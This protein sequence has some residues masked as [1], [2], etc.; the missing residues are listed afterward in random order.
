MGIPIQSRLTSLD[1]SVLYGE[2]YYKQRFGPIPYARNEHWLNFFG[3]IAQNLIDT[4]RPKSVY[5]AGCAWGFL[6]EAFRDRGVEA[7]GCDISAFAIDQVRDDIRPYCSVASLSQPIPAGPYDLVTCIEVLEHMEEWEALQAV[8]EIVKVTGTVLFSST[9]NDF[10]EPTHINVQPLMYWLEVF[11][12]TGFYPDPLFDAGFI[13]PHAFLLRRRAE[14]LPDDF[15]LLY[16]EVLRGRIDRTAFL[17][18]QARVEQLEIEKGRLTFELQRISGNASEF[19]QEDLRAMEASISKETDAWRD[20]QAELQNLRSRLRFSQDQLADARSQVAD[21]NQ[22]IAD[23]QV[24]LVSATIQADEVRNQLEASQKQLSDLHEL[25]TQTA[26]E[27]RQARQSADLLPE[28]KQQLTSVSEELVRWKMEADARASA[29]QQAERL[30]VELEDRLENADR[31]EHLLEEWRTHCNELS[32][33]LET[34]SRRNEL[35]DTQLESISRN[36]G[37]RLILQGRAWLSKNRWR[38]A[39]VR[40]RLEPAIRWCLRRAVNA[41]PT[42]LPTPFRPAPAEIAAVANASLPVEIRSTTSP[43]FRA[44]PADYQ[45]WI[46]EHEPTA[47]QLDIQRKLAGCL[48]YQPKISVLTPVFKVPLD[49]L[50][51]TVDSVIAQTYDNWE[52]CITVPSADNPDASRYLQFEASRDPRIRVKIIEKNEGIS[53]NS[54]LALSLATGEF[55]A[56]LDHDDTLAPF[57]LFEV[58]QLLNQDHAVDFIYSDKDLITEDGKDRFQPLFKPKWS[59]ELM[60]NANYLTH[61]CVMRTQNVR[62]VGG[63]RKETDGAQDWDLFLRLMRRFGKVR[64]IPKVLYHWR[65]ISTSVAQGGLQAKPYADQAQ[66]RAVQDHCEALGLHVEVVRHETGDLRILWPAGEG[67]VSIVYVSGRSDERT[68]QRAKDLSSS[69]TYANYEILLPYGES[70]SF[71]RLRCIGVSQQANLRERIDAAVREASGQTLVFI[72]ECVTPTGSEWLGELVG[73]LRL[74]GVGLVGARLLD[75]RT[76]MLRHCGIVFTEDGC[77]ENIYAGQPEH[78]YE[79]FGGASWYRNWS[80]ISGSCFAIDRDLWIKLGGIEGYPLVPRPD[81]HLS[82]KIRLQVGLR[83]VYNPYARFLQNG[84]AELESPLLSFPAKEGALRASFPDGDPYFNVNLDCQNGRVTYQDKQAGRGKSGGTDYAAD[85]RAL[86]EIFDFSP[87]QFKRSRD[88]QAKRLTRRME[89]VT[90]FLP[91]FSNAFYGGVHT[92]LRFAAAFHQEY[93][94]RS[95]FCI[96]GSSPVTLARSRI[97]A[98][99]PNLADADVIVLNDHHRVNELPESDAA[100]CSLWTT[101]Y[102]SLEFNKTRRK[103]YFIQDDESLFYPAGSISALVEATYGFGFHGICNTVSLLKR[104]QARGGH[105]EFFNPCI[106]P[107]I[108]HDRKRKP[109]QDSAPYTIFCY[110][111][112]DHPRNS[113]ELLAACLRDIKQRLGDEVSL[114]T[115]GAEWDLKEHALEGVVENLGLL[116]YQTTGALYRTCDLGLVMM[117]TRHPSYLPME[118]MACGSVVISNRNPDTAWFLKDGENCLLADPSPTSLTERIMQGIED[119][120]MRRRIAARAKELIAESYSNWREPIEKIHRFMVSQC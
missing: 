50:R 18:R 104:Y 67:R 85:S 4:I 45:G 2:D 54:N 76:H 22:R 81:I 58:T 42:P 100:V 65:Q 77:S 116:N 102:A 40:N 47:A 107:N 74:D 25:R 59:P 8:E 87:S 79:Q 88:I 106:D 89:S 111:R 6:V 19:T 51:A 12:K 7:R 44:G 69:T 31:S 57:A 48:S 83:I 23:V 39:W 71:G 80:A 16:S 43:Q 82:L 63:W 78:V 108:F 15:L 90:W 13:A 41:E 110:A 99:F 49:V 68:L 101:A 113:F 20:N 37:W 35:L 32:A 117:M 95:D 62:D 52:L 36:P 33:S 24:H 86:V 61:L 64:H 26:E 17:Q 94:I 14:P 66:V 30:V 60:L 73:P 115:A 46:K 96:L 28:T 10:T 70:N 97:A 56:L 105:V 38:R 29:H 119:A 114:V 55:L 34:L 9:P 5:D 21:S 3:G 72:D 11:A 84:I 118:L 109:P 92:I 91:D 120:G 1:P 98:A 53:E 27:L 75:A 93:G 103:F 112:P